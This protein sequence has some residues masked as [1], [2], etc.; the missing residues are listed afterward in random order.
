MQEYHVSLEGN[1]LGLPDPFVVV[2]TQNPIEYEGTFPL[3]EA[4]LDRFMIMLH[5]GYPSIDEEI[6]IVERRRTRK[7]DAISLESVV[8]P[9]EFAAMRMLIEDI[10]MCIAT[11]SAIWSKVM[12]RQHRQVSQPAGLAF[13]MKL[14][15]KLGPKCT[16][17]PPVSDDVK[18]FAGRNEPPPD[19]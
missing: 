9:G 16:V 7:D 8:T 11:S 3:P 15:R 19:P 14:A 12:A 10:A 1:T 2:A 5:V 13:A 17:E 6:E 18:T 4:Q